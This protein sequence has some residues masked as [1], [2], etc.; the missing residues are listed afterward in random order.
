MVFDPV[1]PSGIERQCAA[2]R[3]G[4][5]KPSIAFEAVS[6]A[7]DGIAHLHCIGRVKVAPGFHARQNG[8]AL[9]RGAQDAGPKECVIQSVRAR[10]GVGSWSYPHGWARRRQQSEQ[11]EED[12]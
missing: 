12:T 11:R 4:K 2:S 8:V 7:L 10:T 1:I 5:N 3:A 6:Q 9:E